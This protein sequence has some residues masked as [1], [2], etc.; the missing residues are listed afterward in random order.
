MQSAIWGI[1]IAPRQWTAGIMVKQSVKNLRPRIQDPISE[2][3]IR[4]DPGLWNQLPPSDCNRLY[5]GSLFVYCYC[6]CLS[7]SSCFVPPGSEELGWLG[8]DPIHSTM[9]F[10]WEPKSG[11]STIKVWKTTWFR[12]DKESIASYSI[13]MALWLLD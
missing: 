11:P 2:P 9:V 6:Q 1:L 10:Y 4:L 7:V 8:L 5:A 12:Q 13:L 3:P